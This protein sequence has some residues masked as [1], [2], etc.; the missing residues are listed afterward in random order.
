MISERVRVRVDK[1][2][3]MITLIKN[4]SRKQ[5]KEQEELKKN[6]H[7]KYTQRFNCHADLFVKQ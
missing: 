5:R 4:N 1:I 7:K 6:I 3:I 2:I